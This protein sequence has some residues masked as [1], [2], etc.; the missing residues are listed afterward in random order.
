MLVSIV[1]L[2]RGVFI[3]YILYIAQLYRVRHRRRRWESLPPV[4]AAATEARADRPQVVKD[5]VLICY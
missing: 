5:I 2:M 4:S 3:L 1:H